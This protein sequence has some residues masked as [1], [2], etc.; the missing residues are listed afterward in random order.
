MVS[1]SISD[2]SRT[3]DISCTSPI[4]PEDYMLEAVANDTVINPIE[5]TDG[6]VRFYQT[7]GYLVLPGFVRAEEVDALR[8]EVFDVLEANGVS[9]EQLS[10]ATD[11]KDKLRQCSQYLAGSRLDALINS[12]ATLAVASRLIG[13]KAYRYLPFTAVKSAGGGGAFDYHQDNNYTNH[14]PAVGSI[15]IWVSLVDMTPQ[16]G[17]LEVVPRSHLNGQIPSR[18]VGDGHRMLDVD[19]LTLLPVRMNAGDAIA[20]TRWT[21]HGSGKNTT[22]E[23]RVAYALQYHRED[24]KWRDGDTWKPLVETRRFQT[25]PVTKLGKS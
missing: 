3:D 8:E 21:V 15:N 17:C 11:S 4:Y 6:E 22:N 12:P 16:N 2:F 10:K 1:N 24:V 25:L 13:G 14:D 18:D 19:P 23:P 5:L 7:E 9:R 20:F